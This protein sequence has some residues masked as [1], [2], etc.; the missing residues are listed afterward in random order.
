VLAREKVLEKRRWGDFLVH[1]PA[2]QYNSDL[3]PAFVRTGKE[4]DR[5]TEEDSVAPLEQDPV[6]SYI[7]GQMR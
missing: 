3:V 2:L 4:E 1:P 7:S 6:I 5:D